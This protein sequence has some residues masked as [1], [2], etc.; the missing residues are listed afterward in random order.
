MDETLRNRIIFGAS[1]GLVV[2]LAFGLS[3]RSTKASAEELESLRDHQLNNSAAR[4]KATERDLM[5][6]RVA[7]NYQK[8]IDE[9]AA[10]FGL[11]PT[12][13]EKV[14]APNEHRIIVDDNAILTKGKTL[15]S[16]WIT[17]RVAIEKV[18][19]HS[20]GAEIRA[21]HSV[22]Y[23]ENVHTAPIAYFLDARSADKGGCE[24]R[25]ARMHN[26]NALL[27]GETA[28]IVV[29]AG[30]KPVEIHSLEAM[31]LSSLGYMYV[32]QVPAAALGHDSIRATAHA[33]P[34]RAKVC[35]QVPSARLGKAIR[36]QKLAWRDVVDFYTRHS[37]EEYP[38]LWNYRFHAE[39]VTSL[40]IRPR[41]L[42][43]PAE[44]G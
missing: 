3:A 35:S 21:N 6:N 39:G 9:D 30:T 5:M 37:C 33:G 22:V 31:S 28:E 2:L 44:E 23:V 24:V 38:W 18:A 12:S 1:L 8:R 20:G 15:N 26:A 10:S 17:L 42:K 29:C 13:L 36:S 16:D 7:R 41:D 34:R 40:P 19:Y 32:S 43:A 4:A 27:P 25:G 11:Q 14:Q